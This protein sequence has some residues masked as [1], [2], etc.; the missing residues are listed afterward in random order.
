MDD[1]YDD[2]LRSPVIKV[3]SVGIDSEKILRHLSAK[4]IYDIAFS[5]ITTE[6]EEG[7]IKALINDADMIFIVVNAAEI[8][9]LYSAVT[10]AKIA[11][12][13]KMLTVAI[14]TLPPSQTICVDGNTLALSDLVDSLI[15]VE[16]DV[17]ETKQNHFEHACSQIY[18]AI[19]GIATDAIGYGEIRDISDAHKLMPD[20]GIVR[21]ASAKSTGEARAKTATDQAITKLA[22]STLEMKANDG[23][24]INITAPSPLTFQE[25]SDV[26]AQF[27]STGNKPTVMASV[28]AMSHELNLTLYATRLL[29]G[30]GLI[31]KDK[32]A[33]HYIHC[34]GGGV[35]FVNFSHEGASSCLYESV[36]KMLLESGAHLESISYGKHLLSYLGMTKKE[37]KL[38][39]CLN[40]A[41]I[42]SLVV[43]L[44]KEAE[45]LPA[46]F[47]EIRRLLL[48]LQPHRR[49][50]NKAVGAT[51]TLRMAYLLYLS[52]HL[53]H[54]KNAGG[55]NVGK[56]DLMRILTQLD[57][58]APFRILHSESM[59]APLPEAETV[60]IHFALQF[61]EQH[62]DEYIA[63]SQDQA[64]AWSVARGHVDDYRD[65]AL[66]EFGTSLA[67]IAQW[68]FEQKTACR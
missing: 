49:T 53:R 60:S 32:Q 5:A 34:L 27:P 46:Y 30:L 67:L 55:E 48:K 7:E 2:A 51:F 33:A 21:M 10:I 15:A 66:G 20:L 40:S 37:R 57:T 43:N 39:W 65:T 61:L 18:R 4:G 38:L 42:L 26:L 16:L 3:I 25:V 35:P 41:E 63:R 56:S 31:R 23:L 36:W 28:V 45:L 1:T 52:A 50:D 59:S 13:L 22:L 29:A 64:I 8:A 58:G 19:H 6:P 47:N 11:Q 44:P 17:T 14:V 24:L 68:F 9:S 12:K 54:A 62:L